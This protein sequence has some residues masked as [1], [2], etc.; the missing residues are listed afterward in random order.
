MNGVRS[1]DLLF[2]VYKLS[3]YAFDNY[4][5]V[6]YFDTVSIVLESFCGSAWASVSCGFYAW[7]VYRL[8][9]RRWYLALFLGLIIAGPAVW[10]IPSL[11]KGVSMPVL[12]MTNLNNGKYA[13]WSTQFS[14]YYKAWEGLTFGRC[15]IVGLM[16]ASGSGYESV[17]H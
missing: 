16:G 4:P 8:Y 5:S 15:F 6:A 9:G 13:T 2:Q 1:S 10:S 12:D 17:I 11:I 14:V 3:T 7:R